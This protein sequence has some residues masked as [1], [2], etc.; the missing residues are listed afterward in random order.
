MISGSGIILPYDV[1]SIVTVQFGVVQDS[2][3]L[4]H[5]SVY[6]GASSVFV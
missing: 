1:Y 2:L 3:P 6:I 5:S 4:R